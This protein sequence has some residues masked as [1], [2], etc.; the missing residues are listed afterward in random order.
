[1]GVL[2]Q[3]A[4]SPSV[5]GGGQSRCARSCH[6]RDND[7]AGFY[8]VQCSLHDLLYAHIPDRGDVPPHR[9]GESLDL[10]RHGVFCVHCAHHLVYHQRL[11]R[12]RVFSERVVLRACRA[13]CRACTLTASLAAIRG[14]AQYRHASRVRDYPN[15]TAA[16]GRSREPTIHATPLSRITLHRISRPPPSR[17]QTFLPCPIPPQPT[18]ALHTASYPA[19]FI[20]ITTPIPSNPVLFFSSPSRSTRSVTCGRSPIRADHIRPNPFQSSLSNLIPSH[21]YILSGRGWHNQDLHF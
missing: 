14:G 6:P 15:S 20:S 17:S 12:L 11:E 18:A 8:C 2:V 1:M 16:A 4:P 9:Y 5:A 19:Y 13:S 7:S 10:L 21:I 3:P